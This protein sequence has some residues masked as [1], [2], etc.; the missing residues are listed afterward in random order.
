[1]HRWVDRESAR[2]TTGMFVLGRASH[3]S[4]S[5]RR[6]SRK[7]D[8][9]WLTAYLAARDMQTAACRVVATTI[10]C[11]GALPLTLMASPLGPHGLRNQAL[12]IAV[13][14]CCAVMGAL[15]LR[16]RWP[17]KTQSQMCVIVGTVCIAVACLIE[18]T[19]VIGFLGSTSFAVL[20][21]FTVVFHSARLLAV[22]WTVGAAT[23]GVLAVRLAPLDTALAIGSVVLVVL[24][25]VFVAFASA[26][27]TRLIDTEIRPGDIEPLTGLLNR[28][29]FYEQVAALIGARSRS[30]DRYLVVMVINLDSFSLVTGMTGAA[31]G[32]RARVAIGQRLRETVRRDTIVAHV[33]DAEFLIAERFPSPDP[34]PLAERLRD[35]ISTAPLRLTPSIGVVSTPLHPLADHPAH[36]VLD[37]LLALATTAMYDARSAGGNQTRPV[38]SPPLTVLNDD[39]GRGDRAGN[40]RS[41]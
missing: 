3:V 24:S 41:A 40:N 8:H 10:W 21:A 14:V 28:D 13:A 25:N 36:D 37:E 26:M 16:R 22:T 31:S 6:W 2:R 34:T 4:G 20:S 15:W 38:L 12:A 30:D 33:G 19:P 1:M 29:A 11:L 17:S 23:L 32:N 7:I 5:R 39:S 35:T 18:A 9:Y 27:V